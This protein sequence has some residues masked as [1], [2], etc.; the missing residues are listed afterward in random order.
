MQSRSVKSMVKINLA[1]TKKLLKSTHAILI[2]LVLLVLSASGTIAFAGAETN[3]YYGKS[4]LKPM[5]EEDQTT[6]H[7]PGGDR[8]AIQDDETKYTLTDHLGSTRLAVASNNEVSRRADYTPFG[9]TPA[10]TTETGQ[11]TGM[12][13]EPETAT[14]DYHARAY[15]PSIAR[16]LS[17][18]SRREDAS[19]YVYVGNN[20][21]NFVDF[22]GAGKVPLILISGNTRDDRA[23]KEKIA[24]KIFDIYSQNSS[25]D[26]LKKVFFTDHF[27]GH[28][29]RNNSWEPKM[30]FLV[31]RNILLDSSGTPDTTL[32]YDDEH[33]LWFVTDSN[34]D[35]E[36]D[37]KT[38][39]SQLSELRDPESNY[40]KFATDVTIIDMTAGGSGHETLYKELKTL[41]G[42]DPLVVRAKFSLYSRETNIL[43]EGV[44]ETDAKGLFQHIEARRVA[45][46]VST[47]VSQQSELGN[48]ASP[49]TIPAT[50]Q[51]LTDQLSETQHTDEQGTLESH[52]YQFGEMRGVR[53]LEP[54]TKRTT[55]VPESWELAEYGGF[56]EL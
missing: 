37:V 23:M 50:T 15:N 9:Y 6:I 54:Y 28:V 30:N 34:P 43:L 10:N 46:T 13:Y 32:K 53:R 31:T 19:P 40:P 24:S 27:F 52:M 26:H 17:L 47:P 21:I 22:T 20:P 48:G 51:P 18:D 36:I 29:V 33:I 4:S 16:F 39:M 41:N 12:T 25:F 56:H 14:Y 49:T 5:V 3:H 38:A 2:A 35:Q 7:L 8:L 11:Y 55:R 45:L 44:N 1:V 42:R